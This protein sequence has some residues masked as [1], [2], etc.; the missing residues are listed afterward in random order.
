MKE[1]ISF[2][3]SGHSFKVYRIWYN[4]WNGWQTK[5]KGEK[6]PPCHVTPRNKLVNSKQLTMVILL[7]YCNTPTQNFLDN[8]EG[9]QL[10]FHL[11]C[12]PP[13]RKTIQRTPN[14]P[15]AELKNF[16]FAIKSSRKQKGENRPFWTA[17]F[18]NTTLIAKFV[19]S[20]EKS[21]LRCARK[22]HQNNF[23]Y[24]KVS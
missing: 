13:T 18:K 20:L 12:V 19:P 17:I 10:N 23:S 24:S 3:T 5:D 2:S 22:Y 14:P 7:P 1:T 4:H 11:C 8:F 21:A 16:E 15:Q 9:L 6:V